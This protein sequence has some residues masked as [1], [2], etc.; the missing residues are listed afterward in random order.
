[1]EPPVAGERGGVTRFV[2]LLFFP[3]HAAPTAGDA[4]INN[5]GGRSAGA[6]GGKTIF[7][8]ISTTGNSTLIANGGING[9]ERG[10]ILFEGRSTGGM[11]RVEVFG[12]GSL[13][14]SGHLG[15]QGNLGRVV[16]S[17]E[18]DGNV[19]LG[20][21]NL[22][23]GTNDLH[24]AFSGVIQDGGLFGGTGGSLVKV[25]TGTPSS[26]GPHAYTA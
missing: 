12:N 2:S 1:M 10:A 25:G 22:V 9:G 14:I 24:T 4:T 8:N 6:G 23:V 21:Q 18:G 11:S 7:V 15:N 3:G 20:A 26:R 17:I 13:D 16:G 19:F 5:N